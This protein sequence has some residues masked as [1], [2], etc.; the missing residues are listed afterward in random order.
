MCVSVDAGRCSS[1]SAKEP[2]IIGLKRLDT[3]TMELHFFFLKPVDHLCYR[4]QHLLLQGVS[5]LCCGVL[6]CVA[7]CRSVLQ[8]VAV[9]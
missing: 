8:C 4:G 5:V 1:L 9:C 2:R 7:V 6:Q 3:I